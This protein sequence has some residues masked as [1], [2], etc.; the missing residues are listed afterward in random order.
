MFGFG[1]NFLSASLIA[2]KMQYLLFR[3]RLISVLD[4][5]KHANFCIFLIFFLYRW[6]YKLGC[7]RDIWVSSLKN[8]FTREFPLKE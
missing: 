8:R 6:I 5:E 4:V 7:T 1:P 2:Q 3:S